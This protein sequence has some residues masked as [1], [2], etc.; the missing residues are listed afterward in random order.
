MYESIAQLWYNAVSQ[1]SLLA[2]P[3]SVI[4][5]VYGRCIRRRDL[6]KPHPM[7]LSTTA[8]SLN[9]ANRLRKPM[10]EQL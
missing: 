3:N 2:S 5:A 9:L 10:A 4:H 7:S 8:K 1:A 6:I